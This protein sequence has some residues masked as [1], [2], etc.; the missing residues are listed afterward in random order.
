M[1]QTPASSPGIVV[2]GGTASAGRAGRGSESSIAMRKAL[3]ITS[4]TLVATALI[5]LFGVQSAVT[6]GAKPIADITSASSVEAN[7]SYREFRIHNW[8]FDDR[9]LVV[10]KVFA[11]DGNGHDTRVGPF[12]PGDEYPAAGTVLEPHE[13]LTFRVAK[14]FWGDHGMSVV[15]YDPNNTKDT[16]QIW[17][18]SYVFSAFTE[19]KSTRG[20]VMCYGDS[21]VIYAVDPR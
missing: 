6:A 13:S 18:K 20:V 12:L 14:T 5:A 2:D 19:A 10:S 1:G 4:I 7:S 11:T 16:V 17:M 21:A 8:G 9:T 3:R 15:L